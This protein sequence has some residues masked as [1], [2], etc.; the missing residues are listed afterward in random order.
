VI[1][2]VERS[3]LSH[4]NLRDGVN[5]ILGP[6]KFLCSSARRSMFDSS[7]FGSLDFQVLYF[8]QQKLAFGTNEST[9]V[10]HFG[11]DLSTNNKV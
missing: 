7:L 3:C 8:C 10:N 1:K 5:T 11:L 6:V 2:E 4:L 9:S